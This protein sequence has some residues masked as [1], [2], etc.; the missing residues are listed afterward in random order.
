MLRDQR[1]REWLRRFFAVFA[2]ARSVGPK[3]GFYLRKP[4]QMLAP[5]RDSSAL[6]LSVQARFFEERDRT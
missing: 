6:W 3:S 5:Q 2:A 1:H 4:A